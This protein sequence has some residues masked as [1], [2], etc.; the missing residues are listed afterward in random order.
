MDA[1]GTLMLCVSLLLALTR[2]LSSKKLSAVKFGTKGYFTVQTCFFGAGALL[3]LCTCLPSL[4]AP[5]C[6]T[7][8]LALGYAAA[9]LCAQWGYT[10]ALSRAG[11][12]L[13]STVYAL[14]PQPPVSVST[15][16]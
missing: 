14:A 5:T 13:T 1:K 3:L 8:L 16:R 9:L 7:V 4:R 15:A 11:V 6:A 2:T 10:A 12:S